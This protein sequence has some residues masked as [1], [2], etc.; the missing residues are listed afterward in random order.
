[1]TAAEQQ[2]SGG[3]R[4]QF[5]G[6]PQ[7]LVRAPGRVN[8]IG[9]H[10]DYTEG[11]VLPVTINRAVWVA[12][13]PRTDGRFRLYSQ[14]FGATVER[15]GNPEPLVAGQHPE[16]QDYVLGAAWALREHGHRVDGFDAM[17]AGD[18]PLGAG[19]SSSAA[20]CVAVCFALARAFA[21]PIDVR[22]LAFYA[23]RVETGYIGVQCGIMDQMAAAMGLAGHALLIDCRTTEARP[24]WLGL[25][26][27]GIAIVVADSALPRTLAASAYNQR[28]AECITA[29]D[30]ARRLFPARAIAT[31]RDLQEDDLPALARAL[32][33]T[34][35]RRARHI[36]TE[37]GRVQTAVAVLG[38]GDVTAL[39][40]LL[41]SSHVSLR[42]DYAVSTPELDRLVTLARAVPGVLGARLTGA[43]FGGC[44]VNLVER[45]ALAAFQERVIDRY[46]AETGR[47]ATMLVC[48]SANGAA[49]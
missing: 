46:R 42:D 44:T 9:E 5:G 21:L 31:L 6:P 22:R 15:A 29:T 30:A 25:E 47:P 43:G 48:R 32:P 45:T 37:N 1:M 38:H 8:L 17:I 28:V 7:V 24:V 4:A 2:I 49:Y 35:F 13:R 33:E 34:L 3:F 39:G 19:L 18:V 11:F 41:N 40:G 36:V 27:R 12:L 23:R 20:L 16:W 10:T 26:A 14:N